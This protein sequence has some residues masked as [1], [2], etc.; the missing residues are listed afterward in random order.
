M[1][2]SVFSLDQFY[3]TQPPQQISAV[4]VSSVLE[5]LAFSGTPV[6]L[7]IVGSQNPNIAIEEPAIILDVLEDV[8]LMQLPVIK[9]SLNVPTKF[10]AS[11][12]YKRKRAEFLS[13]ILKIEN[14][15]ATVVRPE[16][17][18]LT[19]LRRN[20][21]LQ[22]DSELSKKGLSINLK[23]KT[24]VG[25][26]TITHAELYEISQLGMSIFVDRT[27]GLLL[28]GDVIEAIDI[29]LQGRP[30][31]STTGIVNRVTM[32]RRSESLPNSYELVILFR[33]KRGS[34]GEQ[35]RGAKRTPILDSKPC[36]FS[37]EHPLFPGRRIEGQV[38]EISTS[39]MACLLD[40]TSFPILQGMRF[41]SC[42]LQLP[43]KPN[44]EFVFEVAH[45]E[46]RSDGA[47]NQFRLGGEFVSAPVELVKDISS[48]AQSA[49]GGLVQDVSEEDFDLLW[50]FMFETNFIYQDKRKQIQ[51]K[52]K[53]I[54]ETYHRLL[55]LD[56]PI[57]KKIVFKEDQEI[58]GHVSAVRFFDHCWI[59]QHLNA[60]KSSGG[61]AAQAMISGIVDFFYSAKANANSETFYVMSFYRPDNVY[62]AIV[63]GESCRRINDPLKSMYFDLAFGIYN[64][65][66]ELT[67][68]WAEKIEKNSSTAFIDLAN[69]MIRKK[70]VPFMR[71]IGLGTT[72]TADLKIE[73]QYGDLG[74]MRQ[75]HLLSLSHQSESVYAL[76]EISSPGLNLSELTNAIYLFTDGVNEEVIQKLSEAVLEKAYREY[77]L[78]RE[79]SPVVMQ[80]T[81][82][83]RS[84]SV[85]WS[86]VY[87]C[88]MTSAAHIDAFEQAANTVIK[89]FK[90]LVAAYR[91]LGEAVQQPQEEKRA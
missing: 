91:D 62:P 54:L 4:K 35:P 84:N 74:L 47:N 8:F 43:H 69:L 2:G 40:K 30:V 12:G 26:V 21:R 57:V 88:W 13:E 33:E 63:F 9:A 11:F 49:S 29:S 90:K 83:V 73:K 24:T 67:N 68:P 53:E 48:Y 3:K 87:T 72:T 82:D 6:Y 42:N 41:S 39:G 52:S 56:N 37:A 46:F 31:L 28:P 23:A 70:L 64:P 18:T 85:N 16:M 15:I 59:I 25:D 36:F 66:A 79:M 76:V 7:R 38:F 32:T 45:V 5:Y 1:S 19:N 61:S 81:A 60:L 65:V 14:G 27:Q 55:S 77:F 71:A 89:D 44:R 58:K 10:E 34:K 20:P 86:K 80:P 75:R 51:N 17:M 78:P 22:V 50:E